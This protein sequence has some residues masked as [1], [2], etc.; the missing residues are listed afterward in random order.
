MLET[1]SPLHPLHPRPVS[2]HMLHHSRSLSLAA[3]LTHPLNPLGSLNPPTPSLLQS[4]QPPP[5]P[6]T[7]TPPGFTTHSS[8]HSLAFLP[9]SPSCARPRPQEQET[10]RWLG[11]LGL[12][13]TPLEEA[14]P[15]LAN[16]LRC[17]CGGGGGGRR[18]A[19]DK[20][21]A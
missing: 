21:N 11:S 1:A 2:S 7:P 19:H 20:L 12:E 4:P 16:P 5:H 6:R 17:A 13:P 3:P 18:A 10:R 9:S 14:A 15:F 8:L